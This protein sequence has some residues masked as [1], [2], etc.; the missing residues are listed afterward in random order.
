MKSLQQRSFILFIFLFLGWMPHTALQLQAAAFLTPEISCLEVLP[1]GSVIISWINVEGSVDQ[2][3]I[4]YSEDGGNSYLRVGNLDVYNPGITSFHH[5]TAN[6]NEKSL[7]Y[8]VE[9]VYATE[10]LESAPVQT[11][12]LLALYVPGIV[13]LSWND[14]SLP[15]DYTYEIWQAYPKNNWQLRGE[16]DNYTLYNDT[17]QDGICDDSVFYR[18]EVANPVGCRSVSSIFAGKYSETRQ[19]ISSM[20]DSIS[21]NAAGEVVLSWTPSV[22]ADVVSTIIYLNNFE[23]AN[24]AVT[25]PNQTYVD[26]A[27][28]PCTEP[29]LVYA[30]AAEDNC[31]NR[32]TIEDDRTLTPI[33]LHQPVGDVC[34]EEVT[35]DW[36][37]YINANPPLDGYQILYRLNGDPF[38]TLGEVDPNTTTFTHEQVLPG[39]DYTYAVRAKFGGITSTS[40][41]KIITTASYAKPSYVYLANASVLPDGQVE[42]T[43]DPDLFPIECQWQV[44]R[45]EASG[46]PELAY[47]FNRSDITVSPFIFTDIG[48]N[49]NL[50]A[51]DYRLE[52]ID[53]CEKNTFSS[54]L[55]TTI[56]LTGMA[57]SNEINQL[58][59]TPFSGFDAGIKQY[60]IFRMADGIA[61]SQPIA[62]VLP[63]EE[64]AYTD[65][66]NGVTSASGVFT[67][68]VEAEENQGNTYGYA[69][70]SLS[71]QVT[72]A[73]RT[74]L[75]MPNAF[76]PGGVT[77]TFKP[78][79]LFFNGPS[80]LFQV[81]D[82]W[83]QLIFETHESSEGWEGDVSGK[84]AA[85]GTY[86]YRLVYQ[87]F[88]GKSFEQRGAFT[89]V[90]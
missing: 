32:S 7:Y 50:T 62:S 25:D 10:T 17:L 89:L 46:T 22:S 70:K 29:N 35:L 61:P 76:R 19:P 54:N 48:A 44:W 37:P 4:Y 77:P 59:W 53:S 55:M 33:F 38:V 47:T 74:D 28:N 75:F 40:C 15:G 18:I 13:T 26:A 34:K 14:N 63:G 90:R 23:I 21:V 16:L 52:V 2:Q 43:L 45:T 36:N 86:L 67:Y 87:D 27:V 79:F 30:L 41:Q 82:R 6:A 80:Y 58:N 81:Y 64:L 57:I 78:V 39:E 83:G 11:M 12:Y 84:S 60:H 69:E 5:T 20:F 73:Q 31:A 65:D 51:Y 24:I 42:L 68:W 72:F 49:G 8:Y 9:A 66:L 85:T 3:N 56:H 88:D 1:D 71:N